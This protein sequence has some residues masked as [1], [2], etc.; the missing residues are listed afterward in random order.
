MRR[1]VMKKK[2]TK[3]RLGKETLRSLQGELADVAGGKTYT[4]LPSQCLSACGNP[5]GQPPSNT[6]NSCICG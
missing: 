1:S 5:C 4:S 2:V 3:L 6:I